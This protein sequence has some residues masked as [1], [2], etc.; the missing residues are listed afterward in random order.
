MLLIEKI[1][2]QGGWFIRNPDV[3]HYNALLEAGMEF[4]GK[5]WSRGVYGYAELDNGFVVRRDTKSEHLTE[6][7]VDEEG[8]LFFVE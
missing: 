8:C 7:D 4:E 6:I 3:I 5:H 2:L 1:L